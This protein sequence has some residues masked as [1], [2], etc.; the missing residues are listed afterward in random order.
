MEGKKFHN[1][2]VHTPDDVER[3]HGL[4]GTNMR[5]A[6]SKGDKETFKKHLGN[7][8][9]DKETNNIMNRVKSSLASGAIKV[10]RK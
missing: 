1:I 4:S 6:A 5:T 3:K 7:M 2:T 10:K 8:F 9:S